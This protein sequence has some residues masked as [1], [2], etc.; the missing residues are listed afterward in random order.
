MLS[1][2][3]I[4]K[5]SSIEYMPFAAIGGTGSNSLKLPVADVSVDTVIISTGIEALSNPREAFRD[6]W[7]VLKPRGKCLICFAGSPNVV[8]L[9]PIK[10]WTTMTEE[11]KIWIAGSYYQYSAGQGWENIEGSVFISINLCSDDI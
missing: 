9:Q 4:P 7:R 3:E 5:G 10:M 2:S 6:I 8:D 11:Q 1:N